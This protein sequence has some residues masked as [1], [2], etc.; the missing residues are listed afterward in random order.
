M[1]QAIVF[2][3][4]VQVQLWCYPQF[5]NF[6][7][8]LLWFLNEAVVCPASN[9]ISLIWI[10][11]LKIKEIPRPGKN[12]KCLLFLILLGRTGGSPAPLTHRALWRMGSMVS[13]W[14][15]SR[16]CGGAIEDGGHRWR[17]GG[18]APAVGQ[19]GRWWVGGIIGSLIG[20]PVGHRWSGYRR[21]DNRMV[22][23]RYESG[24]WCAVE[25]EQGRACRGVKSLKFHRPHYYREDH[26]QRLI[27]TT[28][29]GF[30]ITADV[31]LLIIQG[32]EQQF[33]F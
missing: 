17:C 8:L 11:G 23:D 3:P 1:L 31:S 18:W 21:R 22:P 24:E 28:S 9:T 14:S 5:F 10:S 32:Y 16:V 27:T 12:T 2:L 26:L 25:W 4:C 30:W 15:Q 7:I 6:V 20:A 19:L 33:L 13:L 29:C